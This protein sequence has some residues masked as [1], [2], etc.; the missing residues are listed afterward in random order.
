MTTIAFRDGVVASDSR[1]ETGGWIAGHAI[2]KLRKSKTNGCVFAITGDAA[3]ATKLMNALIDIP[4][5]QPPNL[6]ENSRVVCFSADSKITVYEGNGSFEVI[7]EFTAF[8][9]G[10]PAALAAMMMG[11]DARQAVEIAASID[12]YTGGEIITMKVG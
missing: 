7:C 2:A 5:G 4:D 10:A 9:S 6:G 11:A 8:G 3:N 12:P 1:C